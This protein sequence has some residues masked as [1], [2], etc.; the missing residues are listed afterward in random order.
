MI[1]ARQEDIEFYFAPGRAQ[2]WAE[3]YE[4]IWVSESEHCSLDFLSL[5]GVGFAR[6]NG[7]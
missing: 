4:A 3:D 2:A 1:W 5:A 7:N 6:W